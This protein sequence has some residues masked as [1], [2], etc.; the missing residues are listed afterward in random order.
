MVLMK[1]HSLIFNES[2]FN[3]FT[4]QCIKDKNT[5]HLFFDV[6]NHLF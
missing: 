6:Q 3:V 1:D 2:M 5:F 4:I